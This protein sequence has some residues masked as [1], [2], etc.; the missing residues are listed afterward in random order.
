MLQK[1]GFNGFSSTAYSI[2]FHP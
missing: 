2:P 1:K